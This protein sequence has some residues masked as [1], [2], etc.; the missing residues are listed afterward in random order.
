MYSDTNVVL[1]K[2][3]RVPVAAETAQ[4]EPEA[5]EEKTEQVPKQYTMKFKRQGEGLLKVLSGKEDADRRRLVLRQKGTWNLLLNTPLA[6]TRSFN[7]VEAGLACGVK[8]IG[9]DEN[10]TGA[11]AGDV[12]ERLGCSLA[13]YCLKFP[14]ERSVEA[15]MSAVDE[16]SSRSE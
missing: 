4:V 10:P 14:S 5:S 16:Q 15:F 8:F 1:L 11:G 6:V 3:V 2:S 7:R 12:S 13:S 9:I